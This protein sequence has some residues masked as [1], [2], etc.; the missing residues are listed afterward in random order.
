MIDL[1]GDINSHDGESVSPLVEAKPGHWHEEGWFFMTDL[2]FLL[3]ERESSFT[4]TSQKS[5]SLLS[6]AEEA[7]SL[8]SLAADEELNCLAAASLEAAAS[9][10][11]GER[12]ESAK[13]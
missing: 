1:S 3:V 12:K 4:R 6:L 10:L 13:N 7:C 2:P 5:A 9:S 11:D 8:V